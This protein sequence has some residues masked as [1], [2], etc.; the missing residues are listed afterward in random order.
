MNKWAMDYIKH[1]VSEDALLMNIFR[2]CIEFDDFLEIKSKGRDFVLSSFPYVRLSCYSLLLNTTVKPDLGVSA[3]NFLLFGHK[4]GI[5]IPEKILR[6]SKAFKPFISEIM[7]HAAIGALF[8]GRLIDICFDYMI[9]YPD[10]LIFN[11]DNSCSVIWDSYKR[12]GNQN[13]EKL[14]KLSGV[15]V[16][17]PNITM[18]LS[19]GFI[20]GIQDFRGICCL[21]FDYQ[22]GC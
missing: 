14:T 7:K 8:R 1:L 11:E 2:D 15:E 3:L 6:S 5:K 18:R 19:G 22:E 9:P 4:D 13:L 20:S 16:G 21:L 10:N 17:F 12:L